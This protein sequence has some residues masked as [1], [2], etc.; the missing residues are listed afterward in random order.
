MAHFQQLQFVE[1]VARHMAADWAGLRVLEIGSADING[2]V[3]PFFTHSDYTGVDLAAESPGSQSVGWDYYRNLNREDF[4]RRLDL[5]AAGVWPRR[6]Q[7]PGPSRPAAEVP[8]PA[9]RHQ[10]FATEVGPK[11]ARSCLSG[12]RDSVDRRRESGPT[13]AGG[14]MTAGPC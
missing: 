4:E 9:P 3:R 11:S 8:G 7:Y 5:G 10:G 12:I 14:Q 6:D 13:G 2:S 1:M